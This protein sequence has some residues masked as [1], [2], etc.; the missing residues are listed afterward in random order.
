MYCCQGSHFQHGQHGEVC[1]LER[2]HLGGTQALGDLRGGQGRHLTGGQG[3]HLISGQGSDLAGAQRAAGTRCNGDQVSGFQ[4]RYLGS[5]EALAYLRVCQ[6]THLRRSQGDNLVGRQ[7]L[8]KL[9]ACQFLDL[10]CGKASYLGGC[11]AQRDL[12]RGEC[13]QLGRGK[14]GQVTRLQGRYLRC[15]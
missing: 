11:Q 15:A 14:R 3:L 9:G 13:L 12:R 2:G 1:G 4:R 8:A 10:Y 5:I 6:C 7:A